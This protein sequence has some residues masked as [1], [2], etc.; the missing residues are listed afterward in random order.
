M[1]T[2]DYPVPRAGASR[3]NTAKQGMPSHHRVG[4]NFPF[5]LRPR[6]NSRSTPTVTAED[7]RFATI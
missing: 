4:L 3:V 2:I 7:M 5:E 6:Q 1:L